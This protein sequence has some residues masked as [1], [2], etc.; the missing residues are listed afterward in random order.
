[1]NFAYPSQRFQD[2]L[3]QQWCISRGQKIDVEQE[4]WLVGP[5]GN[6]DFIADDF[7]EKLANDEDL[8]IERNVKGEGL[9]TS[10]KDLNLREADERRVQS[11]IM[12]F[13]E[14]TSL[15]NLDISLTW[16]PFFKVGGAVISRLYSK[17][18][19]Q[20][21]FPSDSQELE[22][23]MN[24]ELIVLKDKKT[25]TVKYRVWY[26]T[27]KSSGR[28]LYSGIYGT[29]K[30]PN[31]QT[32][33]KVVFPLPRG[34]ATII[35]EASVSEEGA[36]C[37][38]SEGDAYGDPGFYFLLNDSKGNHWAQYIR[39]FREELK[40][41]VDE[42]GLGAKHSFTLWRRRVMDISYRMKRLKSI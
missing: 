7:I 19:K 3:S 2:W 42:E 16:N 39:S 15:Y 38:S 28:V 32:C 18:L 11:E 17:R 9:L 37:L 27:L 25:D 23:G 24:S 29:C 35:M 5:F 13:Y 14:K 22:Q 21:N 10:I 34:N 12:E 30:L 36:L 8:L 40:V 20:L 26:R 31:G 33:V 1:M 4:S 6:S 41:Y